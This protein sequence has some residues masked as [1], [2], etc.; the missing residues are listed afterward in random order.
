MSAT[1]IAYDLLAVFVAVAE[2]ESFSKAAERLG[3]TKGTV[4]RA[5]ARLERR[6]GAELLHRTTHRVALSTAGTAL[7][8]RTAPHFAALGRALGELPE[9]AAE[10]SGELRITAPHDIAAMILPELI[11]QFSLRYPDVRFD[12]RVTNARLDLVREKIDLAIRV[13]GGKLADSSLRA[14]RLGTAGTRFYAAPSYVA[15]R[16]AP[17]VFGD[18]K[19]EWILL[20]PMRRF[21][22]APKDLRP[23]TTVDDV[24]T[25]RN[26]ALEGVGVT[27]LPHFVAAESVADGRLE[28]VLSARSL[29]QASLF[30]VYPSSGQVPRKVT[31]F[32]EFLAA[33][34]K[35]RPLDAS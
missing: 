31:V 35:A 23:R 11:A 25:A 28:P 17:R 8:E 34:L 12:L 22:D 29:M 19:H 15:R 32:T 33:R 5:I 4:S 9:S 2:A 10:P 20:G 26:L 6:V 1:P 24:I 21:L 27:A 30:V 3:V 7:Y 14:R 18:S 13:G 16:G